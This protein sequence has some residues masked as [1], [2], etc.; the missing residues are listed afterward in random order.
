MYSSLLV[1]VGKPV[2]GR[3]AIFNVVYADMLY[4]VCVVEWCCLSVV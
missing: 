3:V 2:G 4:S 1:P